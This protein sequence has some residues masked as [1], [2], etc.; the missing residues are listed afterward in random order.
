MKAVKI[1]IDD[2]LLE[3]FDTDPDVSRYGRSAVLAQIITDFL[4]S[5]EPAPPKESK[6]GSKSAA[7]KKT[8]S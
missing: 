2:N 8:K 5:K 4:V 1:I 3:R 7:K 6:A